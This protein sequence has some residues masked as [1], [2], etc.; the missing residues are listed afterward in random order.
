MKR[1]FFNG[2]VS[3]I[4][5]AYLVGIYNP[6]VSFTEYLYERPILDGMRGT[7]HKYEYPHPP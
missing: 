4:A 6:D 5:H 1:I 7:K 3:V 2:H